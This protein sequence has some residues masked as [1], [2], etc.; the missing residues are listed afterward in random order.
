MHPKVVSKQWPEMWYLQSGEVKAKASFFPLGQNVVLIP[1]LGSS[2]QSKVLLLTLNTYPLHANQFSIRGLQIPGGLW[3]IAGES[4]VG[5]CKDKLLLIVSA[6][7]TRGPH[8]Q[9]R[10]RQSV[11]KSE[12]R[13]I[14][15]FSPCSLSWG[16]YTPHS[17]LLLSWDL[18]FLWLN[19]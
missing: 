4:E 15:E 6:T 7:P 14:P 11:C 8:L 12:K 2:T 9:E 5:S 19:P 13:R 17:L 18:L 3:T 1:G 16:F 10:K